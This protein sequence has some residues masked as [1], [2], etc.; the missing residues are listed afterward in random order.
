MSPQDSSRVLAINVGS[1]SVK[2]GVYDLDREQTCLESH[3]DR[4]GSVGS[5]LHSI[6]RAMEQVGVEHIDAVGHRVAHGGEEYADPILVN[7]EVEAA[8]E[9]Y[10]ALAPQHNPGSLAGIRS[11]REQW[12]R[13]PQ[14]AVFDTS[15]HRTMPARATTYAVPRAWRDAGLKRY[16]FHGI[17]HQH[18]METVAGH[19]A[20]PA[21]ELRIV[22]CHLGNGASVCAI[23]R[24]LSV[25]TSMGMTP[26]E[27]LVMGSRC[28]DLDPGAYP[29][30]MR[31]L[32][33]S[34]QQIEVALSEDS[35]LKAL[36]GISVDLREVQAHALTGNVQAQLALQIFAYRVRKYIGGY[37]VA[38]GGLDVVAFTGG[39]G[40]SAP[41]VRRDVCQ[42][43]EVLGAHLDEERNDT[44]G[45][46]LGPP[47][48]L[49]QSHSRT[50]ILV[51][52]ARE[53]WVIAKETMRLLV[54]GRTSIRG[55][56]KWQ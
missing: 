48:E 20:L 44:C 41:A 36:S 39:I 51:V 34:A 45:A 26:L 28:G 33:L 15:F 37:A 16:G 47:V 35:G 11:A 32:G 10:A 49:Q 22:S 17:S 7:A 18:V 1:S 24:G 38:M 25:D 27:G 43:L 50:K 30:L 19:L 46:G 52:R 23:D 55:H 53:E 2:F 14:V 6:Q 9:R 31:T 5:A 4:P 56:E 54:A 42:G 3:L 8:I 40:E 21:S 13:V 12:P 29:Y